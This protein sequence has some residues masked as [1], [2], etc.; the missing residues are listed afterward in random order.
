MMLFHNVLLH[1]WVRIF[2]SALPPIW[3]L[4][5]SIKESKSNP[6]PSQSLSEYTN[7]W[8]KHKCRV[9]GIVRGKQRFKRQDFR[10]NTKSRLI[11]FWELNGGKEGLHIHQQVTQMHYYRLSIIYKWQYVSSWS[12]AAKIEHA[13][14]KW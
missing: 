8:S 13:R 6:I 2:Y 11:T 10:I 12:W 14:G 1:T 7:I 5:I 9:L 3:I 4:A